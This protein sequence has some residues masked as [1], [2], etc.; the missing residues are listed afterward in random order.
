MKK[1]LF[2]ILGGILTFATSAQAEPPVCHR[3]EEI[4]EYN[5]EHHKNYKYY[6][7][8]LKA[9]QNNDSIDTPVIPATEQQPAVQPQPTTQPAKVPVKP[10]LAQPPKTNNVSK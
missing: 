8:Y 4:R 2:V 10:V 3:C 6:E 1:T 5:K 9:E 7:D